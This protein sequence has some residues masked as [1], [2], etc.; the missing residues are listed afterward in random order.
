MAD[1]LAHIKT[2]IFPLNP[3]RI[4]VACSAGLDSTVLLLAC[5]KLKLPVE[6]AHVNY[7]LRGADSE[8]DERFLVQL[9]EKLSI[10][11]HVRRI[12]LNKA[13][14]N[15][16]NL[17]ELARKER[18]AYF[19]S[20]LLDDAQAYV[21]LAHHKEDQ[22]ETFFMNLSRNSGVMGLAGMPKKRGKYIRPLLSVSKNDLRSFAAENNISWRED[23][24]NKSLKYTR[25][26]WRNVVLPELRTEISTLDDSVAILT[27]IFQEKQH[28]LENSI[29]SVLQ[30]VRKTATL[31]VPIFESLDAFEQIELCR[32]MNQPFGILETWCNLNHKGTGI[33]LQPSIS[34]PFSKLIYDGDS[35]S[36]MGPFN[37][38]I[39]QIKIEITSTLPGVFHKSEIYLSAEK[40]QG[41][42]KLRQIQTGD[43]IHPIG[44]KGSRLVSDVISDAKLTSLEKQQLYILTDDLHILWVPNLVVSRKAVATK[45]SSEILKISL[46]GK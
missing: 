43:R 30:E 5:H 34:F 3:K 16:G 33:D 40:I 13:L 37:E 10:A 4:L 21:F 25:N 28:S 36:F 1:I 38:E 6:I 12:D 2:A 18:Y 31:S 15:G 11:V 42:L 35:F 45:Q 17:Q 32:Q 26:E 14:K 9:A 23:L 19:Q 39:P 27:K 8:S 20:L 29:H 7:Q 41:E 24:S 44:M 46:V 22:T